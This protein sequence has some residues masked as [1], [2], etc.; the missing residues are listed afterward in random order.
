MVD[1][2][3]KKLMVN[4]IMVSFWRRPKRLSLMIPLVYFLVIVLTVSCSSV[5]LHRIVWHS[6]QTKINEAALQTVSSIETN[7]RLLVD[8]VNNFSKMILLDVNLQRL[9]RL[10]DLYADI[11]T[12]SRVGRD[13][14][15]LIQT[16]PNID[17]VFVFDRSGNWFS[18]GSLHT[19]FAEAR[20]ED[21]AWYDEAV[22]RE[23]KFLLRLNDGGTFAD[24]R[25]ENFVSFIRLIRDIDDTSPLGILV[26]NIPQS[27]FAEAYSML[28]GPGGRLF[29]ILDERHRPI[30]AGAAEES[31]AGVLEYLT[32]YF[33][34]TVAPV[35]GMEASG[36]FSMA[37]GGGEYT[38]SWKV[39]EETGWTFLSVTPNQPLNAEQSTLVLFAL[40]LLVVN[41]IVFYVSSIIISRNVLNPINQL[42]TA[43]DSTGNETF[44][45]MDTVPN[46]QEFG[47]LFAGY[48]RMIDQIRQLLKRIIDEQNMIRK[49]ELNM[50]QA[51]IKP[52]FL[53]NTLDSISSLAM[54]GLNDQ[55]CD[56]LEALGNYYRLSVSKG[57]EVITVGEEIEMVRNYL[58]I[59]KVRYRDL[60]EVEYDIDEDCLQVPILKLVLQ[61]L[62]ENA[63]YH[64]IR[65]M[66]GKGTIKISARR[67]D[68]WLRLAVSDDGVGMPP[69]KVRQ[70]LESSGNGEAGGFG[71]K[72]TMERLR[73]HYN[74]TNEF[75]IDSE[76]GKGTTVT[77][78]IPTGEEGAWKH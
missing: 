43:M 72:G 17:S 58:R 19:F 76:P 49:A 14:H 27:A 13:L 45:K 33:A 24:D 26:I 23:G 12:Q 18:V 2:M 7:V 73:I 46:N 5:I 9:L 11:N 54:S 56:M 6:A 53:Y 48:N 41:G 16:F 30:T 59:Q 32:A 31:H 66:G 70:V 35:S 8:N 20:V 51:Q 78:L 52:H 3:N 50:L 61:P 63:L 67:G 69:E 74:G 28:G 25:G 65:N 62:A 44:V 10:G 36:F 42:L 68:G 34:D 1:I 55:V 15:N 57:R 60:F 71:L 22:K 77:I 21:A 75:R 38:V 40:V 47:R 39:N 37:Y 4:R 29:A 64:G